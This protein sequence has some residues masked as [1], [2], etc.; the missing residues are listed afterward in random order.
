MRFNN[1]SLSNFS[2]SGLGCPT[3]DFDPFRFVFVLFVIYAS[4]RDLRCRVNQVQG[5][6]VENENF[7]HKS[8]KS[9]KQSEKGQKQGLGSQDRKMKNLKEN[10]Y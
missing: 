9:Q 1:N 8:R 7:S 6:L 2:F 4:S 3:P 10:C 5:G